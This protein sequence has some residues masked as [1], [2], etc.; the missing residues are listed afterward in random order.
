MMEVEESRDVMETQYLQICQS[1]L[2]VKAAYRTFGMCRAGR[3]KVGGVF[4]SR[5]GL[6]WLVSIHP[7]GAAE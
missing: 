7:R 4:E 3:T 6:H 1:V 5:A 2:E